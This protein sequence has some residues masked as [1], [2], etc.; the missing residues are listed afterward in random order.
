MNDTPHADDRASDIVTIE[1]PLVSVTETCKALQS[2]DNILHNLCDCT[3]VQCAE[4][5]QP[6]E[7]LRGGLETEQ[8]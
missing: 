5:A 6:F 2:T 1:Q 3:L 7:A 8:E 4:K